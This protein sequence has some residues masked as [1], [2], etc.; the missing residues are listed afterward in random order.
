MKG[1]GEMMTPKQIAKYLKVWMTNL[2]IRFLDFISPKAL[3][4]H[5]CI[6]RFA[7]NNVEMTMVSNA[8]QILCNA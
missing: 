7:E 1:G 3:E 4:N 8:T 5:G 2:L 6:A